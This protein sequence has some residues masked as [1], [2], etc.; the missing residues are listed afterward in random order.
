[1]TEN[2]QLSDLFAQL[3]I[4]HPGRK[5]QQLDNGA[6]VPVRDKDKADIGWSRDDLEAHLDSSRTYGHYM[7]SPA[8]EAKLFVLD[9]DLVSED[10]GEAQHEHY[11]EVRPD[12]ALGPSEIPELEKWYDENLVRRVCNPRQVWQDKSPQEARPWMK[13]QFRAIAEMFTGFIYDSLGIH[14]VSAYSGNKG[15][16]VYGFTGLMPA[17]DIRLI[18]KSV[19]E[20][21]GIFELSNGQ[22]FWKDTTGEFPNFEIEVFPKQDEIEEN[23]Y[24]N[25]VRLPLGKNRKSDDPCFFLDQKAPISEFVPHSDPIALLSG[26]NPFV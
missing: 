22:N 23:K 20:M 9:I 19:M 15:I 5:A 11:Y 3:F 10:R 18:A 1:M 4:A 24:G 6:Y 21:P 26:G 13:L 17:A 8:S 25:L 12:L 16:H 14:T 7:L 2:T